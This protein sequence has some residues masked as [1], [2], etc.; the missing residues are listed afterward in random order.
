MFEYLRI[1]YL[2][3]TYN[4]LLPNGVEHGGR[5]AEIVV[6]VSYQDTSPEQLQ[7]MEATAKK[8]KKATPLLKP[9]MASL[10]QM[11]DN[12]P[13]GPEIK[14]YP[15]IPLVRLGGMTYRN[16]RPGLMHNGL[17]GFHHDTG[18]YSL[19]VDV[20]SHK[21]LKDYADMNPALK[22]SA[23][24]K[25]WMDTFVP[26]LVV[27]DKVYHGVKRISQSDSEVVLSTDDGPI[28]LGAKQLTKFAT[29]NLDDAQERQSKIQFEVQK[30]READQSVL[31]QRRA[32]LVASNV[33]ATSRA[34]A[35]VESVDQQRARIATQLGGSLFLKLL[36]RPQSDDDFLTRAIKEVTYAGADWMIETSINEAFSD[37]PRLVRNVIANV[38]KMGFE[39]KLSLKG[40]V[41]AEIKEEII[42]EID[43]EN[44]GFA[45]TARAAEFIA[46]VF[47]FM[48]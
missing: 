17:L 37:Q 13:P 8:Y 19:Y 20:F 9:R 25:G 31:D 16:V 36:A 7:L 34:D 39:G 4:A 40:L 42:R 10:K 1:S 12:P 45:D 27:G 48:H 29:K 3:P 2:G 24:F 44:P 38:I 22:D 33:P 30:K 21:S 23:E 47:K 28:Q 18:V 26:V 32:A 5:T 43:R 35:Q 41:E 46:K 6:D 14:T 11:L 15:T